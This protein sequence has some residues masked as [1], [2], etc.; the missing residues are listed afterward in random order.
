MA[1]TA[2]GYSVDNAFIRFRNNL[3]CSNDIKF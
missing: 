3:E 2:Q 1:Q